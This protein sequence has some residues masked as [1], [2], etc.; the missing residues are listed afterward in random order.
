MNTINAPKLKKGSFVTVNVP[1]LKYSTIPNA[2][3]MPADTVYQVVKT[4]RVTPDKIRIYHRNMCGSVIVNRN[5]CT[6]VNLPVAS[7]KVGD[8]YVSTGGY[9]QTNVAFY[10]VLSATKAS[11]TVATLGS[12]RNY[13]GPM[14]GEAT[15]VID[16]VGVPKKV[17]VKHTSD[18]T[19]YFNAIWGAAFPWNGSPEFFSEWH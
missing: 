9:E 13:T 1:V 5:D 3:H 2:G 18:G 16:Y 17:R 12:N 6:L 7:V 11:L 19:P 14:C 8:I 4:S 10:K 15:P